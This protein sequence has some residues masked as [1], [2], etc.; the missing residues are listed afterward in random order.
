[1]KP[2]NNIVKDSVAVLLMD[3]TTVKKITL[4]FA[5]DPLETCQGPQT[6]L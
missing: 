6:P 5:V 2:Q 4:I 1:M 3:G